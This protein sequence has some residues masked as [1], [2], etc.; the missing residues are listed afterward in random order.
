VKQVVSRYNT[1]TTIFW[2]RFQMNKLFFQTGVLS[3]LMGL[4]ICLIAFVLADYSVKVAYASCP[5]VTVR[6]NSP[7]VTM[8]ATCTGSQQGCTSRQG[9][10]TATGNFQCDWPSSGSTCVGTGNF[11]PCK[12]TFA[13]KNVSGVCVLNELVVIQ[14]HTAETKTSVSCPG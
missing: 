9:E 2:R 3:T 13:C 8:L 5:N 14:I 1:T 11:V 12:T 4:G 7:C 10:T 6:I